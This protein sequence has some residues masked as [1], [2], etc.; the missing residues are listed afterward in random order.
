MMKSL[1]S[2]GPYRLDKGHKVHQVSEADKQI[3][4]EAR[5]RAAEMGRV[6]KFYFSLSCGLGCARGKDA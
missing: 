6:V 4:A 1:N 2:L 5:A 3:S